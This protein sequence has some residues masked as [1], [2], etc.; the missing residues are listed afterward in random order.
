[1]SNRDRTSQDSASPA[2]AE[3]QK[4]GLFDWWEK[5]AYRCAPS[6]VAG[7]VITNPRVDEF[8]A[9]VKQCECGKWH[10]EFG[11]MCAGCKKKKGKHD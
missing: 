2:E 4:R 11:S 1:M 10:L 9:M 6:P 5:T 8:L 3:Q 7:F